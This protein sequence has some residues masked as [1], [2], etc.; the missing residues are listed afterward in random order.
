VLESG[1]CRFPVPNH[2]LRMKNPRR[3]LHSHQTRQ[4]KHGL[5][6]AAPS[7]T[8]KK[9][10][11]A[12][13]PAPLFKRKKIANS[14][15]QRKKKHVLQIKASCNSCGLRSG[16]WCYPAPGPGLLTADLK[17]AKCAWAVGAGLSPIYALGTGDCW[18]LAACACGCYMLYV[19][20]IY[21]D[22]R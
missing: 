5:Q 20:I 2:R 8:L 15:E 11:L 7:L 6:Y 18:P 3:Q 21:V 9:V 22:N 4:R 19:A 14:T 12:G 13:L 17:S 16:G 10:R 1:R